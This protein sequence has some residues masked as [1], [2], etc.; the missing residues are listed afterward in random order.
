MS[1]ED[2]A[3]DYIQVNDVDGTCPGIVPFWMASFAQRERAAAVREFIEKSEDAMYSV[4]THRP[5]VAHRN[6]FKEMFN[7]DL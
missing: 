2:R 7:E 6:A 4:Y 5:D 1:I 3:R